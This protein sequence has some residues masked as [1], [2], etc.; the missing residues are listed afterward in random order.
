ME[1][2]AFKMLNL[3]N[4][5]SQVCYFA[6]PVLKGIFLKIELI[7]NLVGGGYLKYFDF[8]MGFYVGLL[9]LSSGFDL[10]DGVLFVMSDQFR[11]FLV[12][13]KNKVYSVLDF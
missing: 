12:K 10:A 9:D 8:L 7:S 13:Y 11:G 1:R 3:S 4:L 6:D 2:G 5:L